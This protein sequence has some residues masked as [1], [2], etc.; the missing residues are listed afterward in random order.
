MNH[1]RTLIIIWW[2]L[3]FRI[4]LEDNSTGRHGRIIIVC[5]RFFLS[6]L[7]FFIFLLFSFLFLFLELLFYIDPI[8]VFTNFIQEEAKKLLGIMLLCTK[9]HWKLH[10]YYF[11]E[12]NWCNTRQTSGCILLLGLCCIVILEVRQDR[13]VWIRHLQLVSLALTHCFSQ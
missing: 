3:Y 4:R 5:L 6:T 1:L 2:L 8:Q 9:E 10:V 7:L 11:L 13:T 12:S